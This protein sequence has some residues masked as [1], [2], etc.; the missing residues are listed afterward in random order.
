MGL[1]H[2]HKQNRQIHRQ[3]DASIPGSEKTVLEDQNHRDYDPDE[4]IWFAT[5]LNENSSWILSNRTNNIWLFIILALS[6]R[7]NTDCSLTKELKNI[8]LVKRLVT[9]AS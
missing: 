8:N 5:C 4:E 6:S 7:L 2:L 9:F 3:S 1:Q